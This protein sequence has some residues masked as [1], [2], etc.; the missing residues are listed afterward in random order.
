MRNCH[1]LIVDPDADER[2]LLVDAAELFGADA[3][4][5]GSAEQA[6]G[7]LRGGRFDVIV[8]ELGLGSDDGCAFIAEL[9]RS[10]EPSG[11][12][13]AVAVT[14]VDDA[15]AHD[16]AL[17]AGFQRVMMKPLPPPQLMRAVGELWQ[18]SR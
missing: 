7:L 2:S 4:A 17:E 3:T 5:A 6:H 8:S 14:A 18:R 15:F 11:S 10:S 12:I 13:P 16:R 9:R 1:I